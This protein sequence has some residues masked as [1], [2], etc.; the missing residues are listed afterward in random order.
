[1]YLKVT[2]HEQLQKAEEAIE[3]L[4]AVLCLEKMVHLKWTQTPTTMLEEDFWSF[5][6]MLNT[7]SS[8]EFILDF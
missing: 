3:L 2:T 1:M 5:R 6:K 8:V 4:K 7:D